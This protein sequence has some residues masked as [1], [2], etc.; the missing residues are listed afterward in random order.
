MT[1]QFD[2]GDY[3]L[4]LG[5]LQALFPAWLAQQQYSSILILTD[6]NTRLCCLPVFLQKSGLPTATPVLVIEA[7][8]PHKNIT[9]C[10]QIWQGMLDAQLDRRALVINLGGGVIGDMGGFCAAT[11]KRG[12]DFVQIPTTLL[13]MTDASVGGKLGIDFQGIKNTIGVFCQPAAVFADPAFLQTLPGRE[14]RSGFA[15]IIKHALIGNPVLLQRIQ[16]SGWT[17]TAIAPYSAQDWLQILSESVQVKVK[18][19]QEDPKEKGFR[20]LLNYGHT[21][22]HA[23]ETWYL[24][25]PNPLTHGEAIAMGMICESWVQLQKG[26]SKP[27]VDAIAA[28]LLS[29]FSLPKIPESAFEAVWQIM[30]QDKKN[31]AGSVRA[32]LPAQAPYQMEVLELTRQDLEASLRFFNNY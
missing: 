7:G 1:Y 2:P 32:A 26:L 6:T 15:E 13:A 30:Q 23:L 18:V 29:V 19:V 28:L 31:N 21:I 8:E 27:D 22:G 3:P 10:T 9:T 24:D 14:L 11:W 4:F 16:Q 12:V 25:Q 5:D 20:M 17:P